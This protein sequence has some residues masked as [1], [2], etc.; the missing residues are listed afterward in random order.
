[1]KNNTKLLVLFVILSLL[2]TAGCANKDLDREVRI[3][4]KNGAITS[5]PVP[6]AVEVT[7]DYTEGAE[8]RYMPQY[9]DDHYG[10][11]ED[12]EIELQIIRT[13]HMN[14]EVED[15]FIASQKVE[16]YARKYGGY[17]SN[18]DARA[19][20]NSKHSGTV[21]I[22]VP[23]LH[24]DAV[25]AELSL[26][27]DVQSKTSTGQ[28]VTE[29][30]IDLQARID[31]AEKHE[32]RLVEMFDN[33]TDVDEMMQIE[34]ELSRVREQIE[35]NEGRLRY[36]SNRVAMSTV[37]VRMYEPMPVVKEWGVWKSIKNSFNHMLK[38]LRFM[39]ELLGFLIPL[40]VFGLLVA[41]L[42]RW[43]VRRTRKTRRR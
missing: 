27:G 21:T 4:G 16:A 1:M 25:I 28:D 17:V 29:E 43:L 22:R 7:A 35:R 3:G 24:F 38:T 30:H 15:F 18:S 10:S 2:L 36:L 12:I 19:D 5:K 31:N 37:T 8:P 14:I 20:H 13:A 32:D 23:E 6:V 33:A 26:L 40:A 9:Y 39:I 41:L 34:R 11:G 42:V